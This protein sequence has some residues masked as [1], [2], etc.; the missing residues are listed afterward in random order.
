M[1]KALSRSNELKVKGEELRKLN[2][3]V[4]AAALNRSFLLSLGAEIREPLSLIMGNAELLAVNAE[5]GGTQANLSSIA[6]DI[7]SGATAL[8]ERVSLAKDLCATGTFDDGES[9]RLVIMPLLRDLARKLETKAK[10]VQVRIEVAEPAIAF[11]TLTCKLHLRRMVHLFADS[12][13]SIAT[14]GS[15]LRMTAEAGVGAQTVLRLALPAGPGQNEFSSGF[16][17]ALGLAH[18]LA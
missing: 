16:G 7:R 14:P 1:E 8:L 5:S 12:L 15:I 18:R 11:N 17:V 13:L 6:N 2:A 3:E 10:N 4:E 9:E